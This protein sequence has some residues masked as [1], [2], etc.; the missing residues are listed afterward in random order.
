[1]S[2][3]ILLV[4]DADLFLQV[5][6]MIFERTGARILMARSGREALEVAARERPDIVLLDLVLPDL[7]GDRVCAR[8]KSQAATAAI[9]VVIVTAHGRPEEEARCRES[10]CDGYVTKPI[11]HRELLAKVA[12]LLD[13][14]HRHSLRILVRIEVRGT[15][16]GESFFGTSTDVSASG[17]FLET[18]KPMKIGEDVSVRFF[19]PGHV[20]VALEGRIARED[21]DGAQ[22]G[23]GVKFAR[24][25][26]ALVKYIDSKNP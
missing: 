13:I 15:R 5:E 21:R 18:D 17:M 8:L 2:K 9:P 4:D 16:K 26:P 23:Y 24:M 1:M 25:D 7:H 22:I 12:Q 3:T 6:R 19:L 10:G 11:K 14:P 20:E